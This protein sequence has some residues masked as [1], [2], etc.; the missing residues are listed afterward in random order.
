M[1]QRYRQ[2]GLLPSSSPAA[3][4]EARRWPRQHHRSGSNGVLASSF[5][6]REARR[7]EERRGDHRLL[8]RNF[9]SLARSLAHGRPTAIRRAEK[10]VTRASKSNR[11]ITTA[12]HRACRCPSASGCICSIPSA[13]SFGILPLTRATRKP[14]EDSARRLTACVARCN[15]AA[16]Y[17]AILIATSRP[18]DG[19]M[20][21]SRSVI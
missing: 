18:V 16:E 19:S 12:C 2:R 11:E 4:S 10:H 14:H 21:H 20:I 5:C 9:C 15:A 3:T 6:P 8:R 17:K 1:H 7:D 13:R